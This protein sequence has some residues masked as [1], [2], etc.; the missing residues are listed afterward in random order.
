M[1]SL[2]IDAAV[3][4]LVHHRLKLLHEA[5]TRKQRAPSYSGARID[6][7]AALT[8]VQ[9]S[10]V[11]RQIAELARRA[12]GNLEAGPRGPVAPG[13]PRTGGTSKHAILGSAASMLP[14]LTD[15]AQRRRAWLTD[16][17]RRG[18]PDP[19]FSRLIAPAI[20]VAFSTVDRTAGTPDDAAAAR[21]FA[22]GMLCGVASDVVIGPLLRGADN[23]AARDTARP[24]INPSITSRV[25]SAIRRHVF[26]GVSSEGLLDYLPSEIGAPLRTGFAEALAAAALPFSSGEQRLP[27]SADDL[28]SSYKRMRLA[29]TSWEWWQW[30]LWL[31]FYSVPIAA[32]L[33]IAAAPPESSSRWRASR[34]FR[35]EGL[36]PPPVDAPGEEAWS[37]L[38]TLSL[39]LSA[40]GP[41]VTT[42]WLWSDLPELTGAFSLGTAALAVDVIAAILLGASTAG[43]RRWNEAR[44][45]I[46]GVQA[47][48]RIACL[49]LAIR[50]SGPASS[51]Y[52]MQTIPLWATLVNLLVAWL[53]DATTNERDGD[54]RT[55]EADRNRALILSLV[56]PVA[57]LVLQLALTWTIFKGESLVSFVLGEGWNRLRLEGLVLDDPPYALARV[58]DESTLWTMRPGP[59]RPLLIDRRYPPGSR[60]LLELWWTGAPGL[61]INH[62]GRTL[63][64]RIGDAGAEQVLAIPPSAMTPAELAAWLEANVAPGGVKAQLHAR[65]FHAGDSPEVAHRL[66]WPETVEDIGAE[67][68]PVGDADHR[69]VLNHASRDQLSTPLGQRGPAVALGEGWPIA[70]GPGTAGAE[71]TG[72]GMAAELGVLLALGAASRISDPSKL[73]PKAPNLAP[74]SQVFRR[75]NLDERRAN[76]WRMLI[77]GGAA[78]E[79]PPRTRPAPPATETIPRDDAQPAGAG[80]SPPVLAGSE[81]LANLLGWVPLMRAWSRVAAD[82]E[83]DAN[84]EIAAP[85]NPRIRRDGRW[86]Q[87]T[88]R[89]LSEAV[90]Y[91]FDLP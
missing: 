36:G 85:Y 82:V 68:R 52:W 74:V 83:Q 2:I 26:G 46:P 39:S 16:V 57:M 37:Q 4:T 61:Q 5:L 19:A 70:P 73:P 3:T 1:A 67:L 69:Y 20:D 11:E 22:T 53:A 87:P 41:A 14:S 58:L 88:N 79:K 45:L 89:Q 90:R 54:G 64:F 35:P 18:S 33:P 48:M 60:P 42:F 63:R 30:L 13:A 66:P 27:L 24:Q 8:A 55:T 81:D 75:W 72:V 49:V 32:V 31:L 51:Y 34:L 10:E 56:M 7:P 47:G 43:D 12:L 86:V 17:L 23:V 40:I 78:S 25:E 59:A 76:E 38:A 65:P 6:E 77:A 91:L 71:G 84:A 15:V 62:R 29:S 80:A 50:E 44:W 21:A 28:A 9:I